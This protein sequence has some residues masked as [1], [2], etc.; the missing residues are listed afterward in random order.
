MP[1][2]FILQLVSGLVGAAIAS[3]KGRSAV[4]WFLICFLVPFSVVVLLF[5]PVVRASVRKTRKCA[6]CT[7]SIPE[8]ERVC[9]RCG[10]TQPAS[11]TMVTCPSCGTIVQDA[12][13]CGKCGGPL[14]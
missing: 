1:R 12:K 14:R 6:F 9:P 2:I 3:A 7:A 11:I 10:R 8:E 4:G 5:L 13:T